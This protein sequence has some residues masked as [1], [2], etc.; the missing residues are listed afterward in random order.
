MLGEQISGVPLF[1]VVYDV[2]RK[3][4]FKSLRKKGEDRMIESYVRSYHDGK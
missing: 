4:V 2:I 3:S 1:A